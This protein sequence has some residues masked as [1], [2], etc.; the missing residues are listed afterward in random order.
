MAF[1]LNHSLALSAGVFVNHLETTPDV[2]VWKLDRS[3][4]LLDNDV[5]RRLK[6]HEG[7]VW[8]W[9]SRLIDSARC[10]HGL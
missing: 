10:I 6:G 7:Q 1:C 9:A 4:G 8:A 3:R 5:H 2:L